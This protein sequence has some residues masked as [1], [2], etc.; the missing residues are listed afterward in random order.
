[1]KE[2]FQVATYLIPFIWRAGDGN[3]IN[4]MRGLFAVME[5]LSNWILVMVAWLS[6]FTQNCYIVHLKWVNCTVCKLYLNKVVFKN[7]KHGFALPV[8]LLVYQHYLQLPAK[9]RYF[10]GRREDQTRALSSESSLNHWT[11]REFLSSFLKQTGG[12]FPELSGRGKRH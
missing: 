1:M 5:I 10:G 7:K 2:E 9:I 12:D 8:H 6:N 11:T 4:H 3:G